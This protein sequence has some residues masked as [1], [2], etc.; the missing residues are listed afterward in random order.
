V[1]TIKQPDDPNAT[2]RETDHRQWEKDTAWDNF[3]VAFA[4]M[5]IAAAQLVLFAVQLHAMRRTNDDSANAVKAAQASAKAAELNARAAIGIELPFLK[6]IPRDLLGSHEPVPDEGPY[7]GFVNDGPPV[8]YNVLDFIDVSNLGRTPA[9][10]LAVSVGWLVA[11]VLPDLPP[12][13]QFRRLMNHNLTLAAGGEASLEIYA[14]ITLPNEEVVAAARG[15][16]WLWV[17]GEIEHRDFMDQLQSVRFCWRFANRNAPGEHE[18]YFLSSD[19]NPPAAYIR[20]TTMIN[21]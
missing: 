11:R 5:V 17:F 21:V 3:K 15:E 7:G 6:P 9:Y 16:S 19:G 8:N 12:A 10:S 14:R 4:M 2:A 13:Y 20:R 18:L 1:Q